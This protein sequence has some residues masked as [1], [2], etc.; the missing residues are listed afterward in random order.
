MLQIKAKLNDFVLLPKH[1][2][3]SN[4]SGGIGKKKDSEN[5]NKEIE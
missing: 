4:I 1:N 3:I 5:D 2:G